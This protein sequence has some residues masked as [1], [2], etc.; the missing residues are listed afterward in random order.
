MKRKTLVVGASGMVGREV[1]KSLLARGKKV[2]ATSHSGQSIGNTEHVWFDFHDRVTWNPA[3]TDVDSVFLLAPS[4]ILTE[5]DDLV[6]PFVARLK[7]AGVRKVVCM[8]GLTADRRGAILHELEGAVKETG[9][10]YTLLRPNWFS[11]DFAPGFYLNAIRHT[12]GV[13]VPASNAKVSFIDTRDIAEVAVAA[14]FNAKHDNQEY[15]LTGPKAISHAEACRI[16]SRVAGH[17]IQYM[18]ISDRQ[19][20]VALK[21]QGMRPKAID[22]MVRLYKSTRHGECELVAHGVKRVLGR[23]P[24]SFEK[25]AE[26]YVSMFAP[27]LEHA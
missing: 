3:L 15:V 23:D 4:M 25:Y 16:I 5:A 21:E 6:P 18:S 13:Y 12:G 11:Q 7:E 2:R 14:L 27:A 9:I 20:R 26:D 22:E 10:P 17:D 8:T 24:I 1:V 19:F